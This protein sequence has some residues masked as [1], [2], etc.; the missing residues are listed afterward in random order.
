[1]FVNTLMED[2]EDDNGDDDGD[3]VDTEEAGTHEDEGF[4]DGGATWDLEH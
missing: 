2:N 4:D 3:V 1:V